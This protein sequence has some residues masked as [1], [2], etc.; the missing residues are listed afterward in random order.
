MFSV[1]TNFYNN[2]TKGSTLME[3]FTVTGKLKKYFFTTRDVR[4]VPCHPWFTHRT[5]LFVKKVFSFP[6]T[7]NTS[8]KVGPLVFLL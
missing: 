4:C 2:K 6:V 5:S 1:I 3:M 8:I 7:V